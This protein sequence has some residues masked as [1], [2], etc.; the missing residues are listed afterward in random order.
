MVY[1]LT[2]ESLSIGPSPEGSRSIRLLLL[3]LDPKE[4]IGELW[5][6]LKLTLDLLLRLF[7]FVS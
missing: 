7:D 4:F 5:L 6:E 2:S 1:S 3:G